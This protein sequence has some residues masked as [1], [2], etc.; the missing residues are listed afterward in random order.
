MDIKRTLKEKV[1]ESAEAV[2]KK[3]KLI[4]DM[5]T[6]NEMV[7][8]SVLKPITEPLNEM[9]KSNQN[10]E[11]KPYKMNNINLKN[12]FDDGKIKWGNTVAKR[13]KFSPLEESKSDIDSNDQ[14]IVQES[15]NLHPHH[16]K[17]DSDSNSNESGESDDSDKTD[18]ASFKTTDSYSSPRDDPTW[19]ISSTNFENIPF[20]VRM[21]RGK[22]MLGSQLVVINNR[23]LEVNRHTY[24][25]TE[26]LDEL[27]FKKV[28]NLDIITE[29]DKRIYKILLIETNA[30]RRDYNPNKPIKSNKGRKYLYIIKPLFK[31]SKERLISSDSC[32]QGRGLPSMKKAFR[33]VSYVYWD[34]PNELV[35]RLKLLVA[36]RDAGNT[37]LENEII[38]IIEELREAGLVNK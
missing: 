9:V 7:L 12:E 8:E 26:G 24:N 29:D 13:L 25:I 10:Y 4:R 17:D 33:S 34:D 20:G 30:H 1:L 2:K 11:H 5:K 3:V 15:T 6:T 37:G 36:S 35:E 27:L 32:S 16:D 31:L 23:K 38:S 21:E 22:L 18:D 19:Q 28:P 14:T